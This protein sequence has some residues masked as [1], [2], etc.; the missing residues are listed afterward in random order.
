MRILYHT[1]AF[2]RR[3]RRFLDAANRA[4]VQ[5]GEREAL[6]AEVFQRSSYQIQFLVVDNKKAV[7]EG[8]VVADGQ[9]RSAG[10]RQSGFRSLLR[11]DE[12]GRNKT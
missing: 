9:S 3:K 8:F 10:R 4:R 11:I 12:S 2:L 1:S 7:V 6:P 5:F